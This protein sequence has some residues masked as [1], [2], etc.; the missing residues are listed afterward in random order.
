[1]PSGIHNFIF[2]LLFS[3]KSFG[4]A[5]INLEDRLIPRH[6]AMHKKISSLSQDIIYN[7]SREQMKTP[8]YIALPIA[9]KH[10]TRGSQFVTM[11]NKLGQTMSETHK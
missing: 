1:M 4:A 3:D 7:V 9:L 2:W 11:L 10:I 5:C 6:E 8:K